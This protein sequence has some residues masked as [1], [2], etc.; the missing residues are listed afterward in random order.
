MTTKFIKVKWHKRPFGKSCLHCGRSAVVT[1]LR[2]QEKKYRLPVRYCE[3]HA[4][5]QGIVARQE[6]S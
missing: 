4:E 2:V 5:L 1:A 3:E 6:A